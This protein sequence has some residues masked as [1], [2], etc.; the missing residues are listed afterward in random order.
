MPTLRELLDRRKTPS[1]VPPPEQPAPH[2]LIESEEATRREKVAAPGLAL[3]ELVMTPAERECD[4][5]HRAWCSD[6]DPAHERH[7]MRLYAAAAVRA[8]LPCY[9][10]DVDI[11]AAGWVAWAEGDEV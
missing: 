8:G 4:H 10:D 1:A 7:H 11:G 9:V 6:R 5:A 2:Q 3:E